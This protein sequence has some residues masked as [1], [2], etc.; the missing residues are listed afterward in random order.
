M[1]LTRWGTRRDRSE[2]A[3]RKALWQAGAKFLL[4][5]P[6]DLLVLFRGKVFLLECKTGKGKATRGQELLVEDGWPVIFVK[7][8]EEAL[9]AIGALE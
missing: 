1:S 8:P 9:Q 2:P 4:L 5:D 7:T 3:I 6:F